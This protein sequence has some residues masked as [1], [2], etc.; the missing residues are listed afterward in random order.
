MFPD[1]AK[2]IDVR[3][4]RKA[5]TADHAYALGFGLH[6]VES[7]A[8]ADLVKLDAV[9]TFEEIE[10]IPRTAKLA[11]RGELQ[12]DLLLLLD[13]PFDLAIFDRAQRVGRDLVALALG[14]RLFQCRGPQQAADMVGAEWRR[15]ALH[16]FPPV[17]LLHLCS[18]S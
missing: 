14:A 3:M 9:Q 12:P 16:P 10:L 6:T 13:R 18:W 4:R 17:G 15:G 8:F 5:D 2:I 7:D 11:V 1:K